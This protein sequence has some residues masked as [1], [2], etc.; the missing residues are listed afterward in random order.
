MIVQCE[1][2]VRL[3]RQAFVKELLEKVFANLLTHEHATTSRV[4]VWTASTA[5]HLQDVG[6]R[7]IDISMLLA[8]NADLQC[9]KRP[10]LYTG[11]TDLEQLTFERLHT[12]N[13]NHVRSQWNAPCCVLRRDND[14]NCARSV[15]VLDY[16]LVLLR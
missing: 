10:H 6:E 16:L 15:Q 8:C 2:Q 7:V 9:Q 4:M 5:H 11:Y 12:H 3:D 14:L 13:D 1:V